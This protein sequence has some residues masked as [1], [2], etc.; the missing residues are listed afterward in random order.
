MIH[1]V[2]VGNADARRMAHQVA[3]RPAPEKP[4]V[5]IVELRFFERRAHDARRI[6]FVNL[7]P[8]EKEQIG[9]MLLKCA[10]SSGHPGTRRDLSSDRSDSARACHRSAARN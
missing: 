9:L 7:I 3:E 8:R 1:V 5:Q 6:P 2:I 10:A 4:F